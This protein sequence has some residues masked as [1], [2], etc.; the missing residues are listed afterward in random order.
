MNELV[1]ILGYI[2][3]CDIYG[4]VGITRM[5]VPYKSYTTNWFFRI[6]NE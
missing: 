3:Y 4:L 1:K 6:N 5:I 2:N